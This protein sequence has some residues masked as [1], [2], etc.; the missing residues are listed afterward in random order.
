MS[1]D[2]SIGSESFNYTSNVSNLFYDH[3][4]VKRSRGG[5]HEIDGLTGAQ[6]ARVLGEAFG[7][8]NGTRHRLYVD[9]ARGEPR[10]D[11][12]Y[13]AANGWGSAIGGIIFLGEIMGACVANP[14]KRVRVWA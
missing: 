14:R 12:E 5:I 1:Y 2:V 6:A 11:L 7:R 13:S 8:M 3:I 10:F 9:G 4:P